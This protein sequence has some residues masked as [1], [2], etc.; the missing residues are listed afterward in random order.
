MYETHI[1]HTTEIQP[2]CRQMMAAWCLYFNDHTGQFVV[3]GY[4]WELCSIW[5]QA[6]GQISVHDLSCLSGHRI[7]E[8]WVLWTGFEW[9]LRMKHSNEAEKI[10]S[11][12]RMLFGQ[13]N[14]RK[15]GEQQV[16]V[17][18]VRQRRRGPQTLGVY[19]SMDCQQRRYWDGTVADVHK[20]ILSTVQTLNSAR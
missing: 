12:K 14:N 16:T 15:T 9:N 4:H 3:I 8:H 5:I 20:D 17:E 6:S 19:L 2:W 1:C 10:L 7:A 18:S 11:K 13:V